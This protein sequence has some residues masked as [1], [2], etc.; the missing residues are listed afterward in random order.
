MSPDTVLGSCSYDAIEGGRETTHLDERGWEYRHEV[1]PESGGDVG[2]DGVGGR[3]AGG[4]E[5]HAVGHDLGETG[6]WNSFRQHLIATLSPLETLLSSAKTDP[7]DQQ[8]HVVYSSPWTSSDR[9]YV[10]AGPS[11]RTAAGRLCCG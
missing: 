4:Q 9:S 1:G 2:R 6:I 3:E 11:D 5:C 7:S 8:S 10:Q